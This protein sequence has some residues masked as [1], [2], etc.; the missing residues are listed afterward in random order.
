MRV[1]VIGAGIMGPGIAEVCTEAGLEVVLQSRSR[2]NLDAALDRIRKNQRDLVAAGL[3]TEAAATGALTRLRLTQDLAEAV[4]GAA[5][6]SENIPEDL[7]LKQAFIRNLSRLARPD[8]ILASNTSGLSISAIAASADRPERVVGFHWLNPPHLTLPVE[9]TR[10][11]K[12]SEE[13]MRATV[14]LAQRIGRRP[15]RVE[16]DTPGFLWNRLQMALVREA[17]HIVEQ[18]VA[19]PEDVDEAMRWGLAL[20]WTAVGPFQIMD[21]A[22]LTTFRAVASYVYPDLSSASKPHALL[23]DLIARG[24]TGAR[25]GKGFHEYGPG[26]HEALIR[27]RDARLIALRRAMTEEE[28]GEA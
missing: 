11:A 17:V 28:A 22:G 20:R 23:E 26:A 12:T 6:V 7:A 14:T 4:T 21:L 9:I 27:A 25:A 5:F 10:G 3:L 13:T 2:D 1:A 24:H 8:A 19:T 15:F 16:R 18:G